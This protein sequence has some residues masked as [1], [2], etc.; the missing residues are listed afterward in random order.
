[1]GELHIY[2]VEGMDEYLPKQVYYGNVGRVQS[3]LDSMS[4]CFFPEADS[5]YFR[6]QQKQNML[7]MFNIARN[8]TLCDMRKNLTIRKMNW[9]VEKIIE[10]V[11]ENKCNYDGYC[12]F[13]EASA[14]YPKDS[15]YRKVEIEVTDCADNRFF[16]WYDIDYQLYISEEN[17]LKRDYSDKLLAYTC[18]LLELYGKYFEKDLKSVG[19]RI[20]M[21]GDKCFGGRGFIEWS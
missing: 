21:N 19:F 9:Y 11:S 2:E 16:K 4:S 8:L 20:N 13:L 12:V 6:E 17:Y 5:K 15:K 7:R 1:M 18:N 10:L 3:F 14:Y